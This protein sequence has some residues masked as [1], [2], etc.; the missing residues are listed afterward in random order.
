[1]ATFDLTVWATIVGTWVLVVGTLIFA[2]WQLRQAQRLH[3][4]TTLLD[5]RERYYG[6]RLRRA[7]HQLSSWLLSERRTDDSDNW[8]VGVFFEQ[9]G[10]LTH[11]GVLEKR[12]VW[13]AFGT[14]LAAYYYFLTHPDDLI[15]RWRK[16]GNDPLVFREFEWLAKEMMTLEGRL[17]V[18][19]GGE[20]YTEDDARFVLEAETRANAAPSELD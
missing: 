2:Y 12:M 15:A 7:R 3:S 20:R 9:L 5:L 17:L 1:M 4:A 10:F 19:T 14:W 6:P 18:Q 16:E 11:S 8:E 13:N